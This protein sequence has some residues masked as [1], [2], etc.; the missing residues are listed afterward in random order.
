MS[1]GMPVE[2]PSRVSMPEHF[3]AGAAAKPDDDALSL[4]S[5]DADCGPCPEA[6][7]GEECSATPEVGE[8]LIFFD[9]DDTLF[10]TTALGAVGLLDS[11]VD[12]SEDMSEQLQRLDTAVSAT[13]SRAKAR[14]RVIVVTNASHGWVEMSSRKYMPATEAALQV[15]EIVSARTAYEQHGLFQ[16]T[17]WK[18]RAFADRIAPDAALLDLQRR[19]IISIGD[20]LHEREALLWATQDMQDCWGKALKFVDRPSLE[21]LLEQHELIVGCIDDVVDHDGPMDCEV[22]EECQ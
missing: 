10:P 4:A 8:A 17:L 15:I 12:P 11:L 14:G 18:C 3:E 7:S 13:L 5:T 9:W 19:S 21:S 16:P 6:T 22:G 20:S 1:A 2:H